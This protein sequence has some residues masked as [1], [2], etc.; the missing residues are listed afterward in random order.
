MAPGANEAAL[1][2]G[3]A[4]WW[5]ML[6]VMARWA[7]WNPGIDW[8]REIKAERKTRERVRMHGTPATG[9]VSGMKVLELDAMLESSPTLEMW[10][11]DAS[12]WVPVE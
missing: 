12:R 6:G 1:T 9:E 5:L 10:D 8:W 3:E 2:L 4:G 7:L 11:E